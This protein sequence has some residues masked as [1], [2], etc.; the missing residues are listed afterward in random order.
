MIL[1]QWWLTG[2]PWA[3]CSPRSFPLS[4]QNTNER[5]WKKMIFRK[6]CH[7]IYLAGMAHHEVYC[8]KFEGPIAPRRDMCWVRMS[9]EE[10]QSKHNSQQRNLLF[11]A[12][13]A[14]FFT[15]HRLQPTGCKHWRCL[16]EVWSCSF[17]VTS[18]GGWCCKMS[19]DILFNYYVNLFVWNDRNY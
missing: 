18:G 1:R 12:L 19:D 3:T 8:P 17:C 15:V 10:S 13:C 7:H 16:W 11:N 9:E 5:K 2:G 4:L 6:N 14:G